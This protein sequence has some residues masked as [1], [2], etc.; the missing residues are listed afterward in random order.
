MCQ[1]QSIDKNELASSAG[2][3]IYD[4]GAARHPEQTKWY[5]TKTSEMRKSMNIWKEM[6]HDK[7][8]DIRA[9]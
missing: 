6:T 9:R 5:P 1:G 8:H 4:R 7:H 2:N 3:G